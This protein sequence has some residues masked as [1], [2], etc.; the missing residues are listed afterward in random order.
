MISYSSIFNCNKW[1]KEPIYT[2]KTGEA[3]DIQNILKNF[4]QN[5]CR[6][7]KMLY[8]CNRKQTKSEAGCSSAR[9][10]Y[11]SGGRGVAGSNPVIP[12]TKWFYKYL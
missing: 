5:A 10:E 7:T 8:L 11:T 1:T 2:R 9:L 6:F 12:T 4:L 3:E